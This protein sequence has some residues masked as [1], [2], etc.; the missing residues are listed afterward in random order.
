[1]E[2]RKKYQIQGTEAYPHVG[3]MIGEYLRKHNIINATVA[4][5]IGIAPNGIGYYLEQESLQLGII[6]KVGI[7]VG[8]DFLA[9]IAAM[10]PYKMP[11]ERELQL[12]SEI[13][14]LKK[15]LEIYKR[16]VGK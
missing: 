15:E 4:R 5:R 14:D 7:A 8:H 9:E 12:E 6:W 11:S 13:E 16:I 10:H 2:F 1:M 3:K